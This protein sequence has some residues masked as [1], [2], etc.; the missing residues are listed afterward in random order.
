[1][2]VLVEIERRR[3]GRKE[4]PTLG[5]I[6]SQSVPTTECGGPRG[7]DMGKRIKGREAPCTWSVDV[8]GNT[9]AEDQSSSS[10]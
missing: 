4:V 1:M 8:D 2:D 6:D 3:A 10:S 7:L 5:I 9:P